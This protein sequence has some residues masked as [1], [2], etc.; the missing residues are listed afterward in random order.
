MA[1]ERRS[2]APVLKSHV[3]ISTLPLWGGHSKAK[4]NTKTTLYKGV[5]LL[6]F[7]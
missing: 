6:L 3:V 5:F 4:L 2:K 7:N 1:F